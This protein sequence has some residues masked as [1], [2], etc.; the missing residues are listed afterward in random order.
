ML[1]NSPRI[2]VCIATFN[3]EKYIGQQ[4]DSLCE[5]L[6][7][8]DEIIISDDG[9]TDG[10]LDVVRDYHDPRIIILEHKDKFAKFKNDY[11]THNFENALMHAEGEII[12]LSDQDD[13]WLPN[14]VERMVDALKYN[15]VVMSDCSMTDSSLNIVHKSYF[16]TERN[17]KQSIFYNFV[18]PSFLGSCM[19][20]RKCVLDQALPFPKYGVGHDLW[21]GLVGMT[22]YRFFFIN[23]PLILYRRHNSSVTDGG[24]VNNTSLWFKIRYR[25]YV[26]LALYRLFM[27]KN[28]K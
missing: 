25:A 12:F 20:F 3:G 11:V 18:K 14:K 13:V 21:L 19:A 2:S 1:S 27:M 26:L 8:C 7:A 22:L 15:D 17:F 6:S 5:Q 24:K 10:T 16:T 28:N 9:S 23:E 4:L